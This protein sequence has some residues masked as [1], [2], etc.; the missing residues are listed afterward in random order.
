MPYNFTN[1]IEV[2]AQ[3]K[4]ITIYEWKIIYCEYQSKQV[5]LLES[6]FEDRGIRSFLSTKGGI[7]NVTRMYYFNVVNAVVL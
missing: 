7:E 4:N 3:A 6:F 5:Q 2:E 1:N